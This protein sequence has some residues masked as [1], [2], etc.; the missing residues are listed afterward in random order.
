MLVRDYICQNRAQDQIINLWVVDERYPEYSC[1]LVSAPGYQ[2]V[3]SYHGKLAFKGLVS[4]IAGHSIVNK[5]VNL[6]VDLD[7]SERG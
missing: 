4:Q 6:E 3:D 5:H 2:L 1:L 7:N